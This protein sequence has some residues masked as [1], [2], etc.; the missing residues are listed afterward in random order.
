MKNM[1][2]LETRLA[3]WKPRRPSDR[4]RSRLFEAGAVEADGVGRAW[5]G[6]LLNWRHAV[7][8]GAAACGLALLCMAGNRAEWLRRVRSAGEGGLA[9][10]AALSNQSASAYVAAAQVAH[11]TWTA[12]ILGWTNRG[13]I[14]STT[15]S[16]EPLTTN[17]WLPKL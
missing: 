13:P 11:N 9:V 5:P 4:I 3:C 17:Q 10:L 7:W 8:V 12:P 2:S 16:L 6:W 14:P 1:D 15:R